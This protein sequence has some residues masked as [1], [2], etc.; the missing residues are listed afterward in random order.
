MQ[1]KLRLAGWPW[2]SGSYP[3][4]ALMEDDS[5]SGNPTLQLIAG[6]IYAY[7]RGACHLFARNRPPSYILQRGCGSHMDARRSGRTKI[8]S[9]V[10]DYEAAL[11]AV[12]NGY[13]LVNAPT[14]YN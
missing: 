3:P 4:G 13:S 8:L 5:S 7:E 11:R 2:L 10:P 9:S 12:H 14:P 1:R 6:Y